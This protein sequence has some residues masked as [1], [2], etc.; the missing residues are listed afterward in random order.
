[1]K[2]KW[3]ERTEYEKAQISKIS[4]KK[5]KENRMIPCTCD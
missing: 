2:E 1:M 3:R 4:I 5:T